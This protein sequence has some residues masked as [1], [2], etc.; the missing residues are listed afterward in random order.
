MVKEQVKKDELGRSILVKSWLT[1][2]G[3]EETVE[4]VLDDQRYFLSRKQ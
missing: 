4:Y 3:S 2:H 1:E